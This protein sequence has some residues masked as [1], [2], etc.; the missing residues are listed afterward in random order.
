ML[1]LSKP[2]ASP[3]KYDLDWLRV[4]AF[5]LLIFYH[6][7]MFFVGWG[8]H[9]KNNEISEAMEWPM[10]FLS[11]WR[12]PLLFMISG[13]GVYFALGRRSGGTF[14]AERTKR[15]L[16][17]LIFGMFV[18]VPPQIYYERL[19]QGATFSYLEFYRTVFDFIP[20]PEGSFSWHHLWYLA[21]I[22]TYSLICLPLFLYLRSEK[23]K[24]TM[25]S[26]AQF[27]SSIGGI[28]LIMIPLF[29]SEA[30]LRPFWPTNQN[31]IADWANF[32]LSLLLFIYGFILCSQEKIRQRIEDLRYISL[33]IAIVAVTI[34]VI[35]Y[36]IHW[37]DPSPAGMVLYRALTVI[38]GWCWLMAIFGF[39]RK[40]L[41]FSNR[42]LHYANEAVYPFYILHQTIIICIAYYMINWQMSISLKFLIISS[43]MFLITLFLYECIIRRVKVLRV[44]F[45]L[46]SNIKTKGKA[47]PA[48][49]GTQLA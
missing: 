43:S 26:L 9:I 20:Y 14:L 38:N 25:H 5:T 10:R 46:K 7:G 27:L 32:T 30:S 17:P 19:T 31:L 33:C 35:Y 42:F 1:P 6:T 29:I 13:A 49:G 2:T 18:I 15:I 3:R 28:Y 23:G 47:I 45:G 37:P 24:K 16:L 4:L 44:L 8:W 48:S 39:A 22:F 21:Y 34:L 41:N 12:M 36:W 11:Q 40:H